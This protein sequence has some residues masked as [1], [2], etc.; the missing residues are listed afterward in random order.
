LTQV[1]STT[2]LTTI[3]PLPTADEGRGPQIAGE[4]DLGGRGDR[5]PAGT[6]ASA[7]RGYL[8]QRDKPLCLR[9]AREFIANKQPKTMTLHGLV[10][11]VMPNIEISCRPA[12]VPNLSKSAILTY[13]NP[14]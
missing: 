12:S 4:R 7:I 14:D 3:W 9:C 8:S 13:I 2:A 6:T 11:D 10:V 1:T 5:K